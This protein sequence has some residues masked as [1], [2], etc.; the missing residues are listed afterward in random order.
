MPAGT[1]QYNDMYVLSQSTAFQ[2][3][4]QAALVATCVSVSN[5]GW[6]VPFH[7]ER[8]GFVNSVLA[9]Q[10]SLGSF[11]VLFSMAA[12]CGATVIADATQ[13]ASNYTA[14]TTGNVATQQALV[15]DTDL[16]NAIS[17][18]FNSFIREPGF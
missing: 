14:L 4:V 17:S 13:S 7:R 18:A 3:R 10:S 9:S 16:A 1:P 2:N 12:A 6:S 11:V 15:T 8:A 5:E